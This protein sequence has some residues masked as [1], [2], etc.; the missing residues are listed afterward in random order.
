VKPSFAQKYYSD[1]IERIIRMLRNMAQLARQNE[2][3][4]LVDRIE[5]T[6]GRETGK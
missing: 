6:L 1:D 5:A 2:Q 4:D 3:K